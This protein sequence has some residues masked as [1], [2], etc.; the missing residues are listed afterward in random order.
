MK[1]ILLIAFALSALLA[2]HAYDFKVGDLAYNINTD[3]NTKVY[4]TY[5]SNVIQSDPTLN[6]YYGVTNVNIPETVKYN[7]KTYTVTGIDAYTFNYTGIQSIKFPK[8]INRIGT[9]AFHGCQLKTMYIN[10]LAAWCNIDY[11]YTPSDIYAMSCCPTDNNF[12]VEIYVNGKLATDIVIP[13][14][15]TELKPCAFYHWNSMKSITINKNLKKI[16]SNA[17][18]WCNDL[19][20]VKIPD[21]ET[22]CGIEFD[23]NPLATAKHLYIGDQ[24]V[25]N[26]VIPE[27]VTELSDGI[28]KNCESLETVTFH[29]KLTKIGVIAFQGCKGL[30]SVTIPYSVIGLYRQTFYSCSNLTEVYMESYTPIEYGY[31]F[32]ETK[33]IYVPRRHIN[34][35][36]ATGWKNHTIKAWDPF[37]GDLNEDYETNTGDVSTLYGA[38]LSGKSLDYWDLN[39]DGVVNTGDVSTLYQI[40]L[41][42]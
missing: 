33:T 37:P 4:V 41:N 25:K 30:T 9:H 27:S 2:A 31:P 29:R 34:D 11:E 22:W 13:S 36:R 42:N 19:T 32:S 18:T 5:T 12:D 35:W 16:G 7:G 14:S 3:D 1:R 21:I 40:I 6:N 24:E 10:D 20:A 28:F 39:G 17:F 15:V 23:S 8:T 38:I 26:L